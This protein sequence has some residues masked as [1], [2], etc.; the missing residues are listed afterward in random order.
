MSQ[1]SSG[2]AHHILPLRT[3]LAVFTFLIVMTG[4][5]VFVALFDLGEMNIIV[6][7]IVAAAKATAVAAIFMHLKYD[8]KL[9][10]LAFVIGILCLAIFITLTLVDTEFRGNV[11]EA[12]ARPIVPQVVLP[13]MGLSHGHEGEEGAEG[14]HAAGTADSTAATH[15]MSK[16]SASIPTT[17]SNHSPAA[18]SGH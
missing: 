13:D 10:M 12:K 15:E 11:D 16:D 6:A 8:N 3:Y 4:V 7:M 18:E 9:Y 2:H 17:D 14:E 1:Q 5:T